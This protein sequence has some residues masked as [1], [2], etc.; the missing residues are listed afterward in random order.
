[1]TISVGDPFPSVTVKTWDD[2]PVDLAVGELIAGKTAVIFGV[3]GA[4]TPTC[5]MRHLPGFVDLYDDIKAKGVDVI[6]VHSVNDP[7]VLNMWNKDQGHEGIAT[8]ADWDAT[9][10]KALGVEAD[11]SKTG[12][13]LRAARY[14]A[15]VRDGRI[16]YFEVGNLEVSGA[17]V[18][19]E[20]LD[21]C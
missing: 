8:L 18:I 4:F 5:S 1:M 16:T 11:M 19:L 13:G 20:A 2:A 7:Y 9:L 17:E 12:L 21:Q 3:P 6:A 10:A 15:I 14:A